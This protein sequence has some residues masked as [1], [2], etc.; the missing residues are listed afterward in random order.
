MSLDSYA[1]D[2]EIT[3]T[4]VERTPR[5]QAEPFGW[6]I[7]CVCGYKAGPYAAGLVIYANKVRDRHETSCLWPKGATA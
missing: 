7:R 6:M 1:I 4:V 3:G 2:S 5:G